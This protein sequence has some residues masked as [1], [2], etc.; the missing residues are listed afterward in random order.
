MMYNVPILVILFNRPDFCKQLFEKLAELKP[1]KLYV[2]ADGPRDHDD[3]VAINKSKAIFQNIFWECIVEYNFSP[4]NIGLKQ[5]ITS[6]IN[7]AFEKEEKLIIL[8]DD[9]IPHHDFFSFCELMLHT[10]ESDSRIMTI[11]GCNLNPKIS[12]NYTES[13]FFSRYAN[14]WGWATWKRAW[15][16]YD[17]K[18]IGYSENKIFDN[19]SYMLYAN[20]RAVFYWKYILRKVHASQIESWAYR[21]MFTLWSQNGLAIVPRTN[22]IHNIGNDNRSTHTKGKYDYLKIQTNSLDINNIN[23]PFLIM[24]DHLYDKN[25]ENSVY[26]KSLFYRLKWLFNK[27]LLKY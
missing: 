26:S 17:S 15:E 23:H 10:Y 16:K 25:L 11:N 12:K 27:I 7:W 9:C 18:L 19:L 6:G 5:R 4:I 24:P 3:E 2:I 8:E 22:L 21:W 20:N 14:S 13:Y 1:S